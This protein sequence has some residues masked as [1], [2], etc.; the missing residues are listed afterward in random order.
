MQRRIA[1]LYIFLYGSTFCADLRINSDLSG[2][3][4]IAVPKLCV[5]CPHP[6]PEFQTREHFLNALAGKF[7]EDRTLCSLKISKPSVVQVANLP[8]IE[9]WRLLEAGMRIEEPLV[10]PCLNDT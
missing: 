8:F 2:N 7:S 3:G 10:R 1:L 9:R 5:F 4:C 6:V